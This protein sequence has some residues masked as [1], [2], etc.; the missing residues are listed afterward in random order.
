M[1]RLYSAHI[2]L[3]VPGGMVVVN[4]DHGNDHAHDDL[5]L[6]IRDSFEAARRKLQAAK[7]ASPRQ[8]RAAKQSN[9]ARAEAVGERQD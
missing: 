2:E 1:G 6:A 5:H 7:T 3:T 8:S 4:R 9:L